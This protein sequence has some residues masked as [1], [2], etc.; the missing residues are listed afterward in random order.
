VDKKWTFGLSCS[1]E[2]FF[3]TKSGLLD[4]NTSPYGQ[5]VDFWM[6]NCLIEAAKPSKRLIDI[7]SAQ[8]P[9]T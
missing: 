2:A 6:D 1:P 8:T 4:G 7:P 3:W 9:G 5:K